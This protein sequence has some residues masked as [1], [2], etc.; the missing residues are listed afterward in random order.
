MCDQKSG[1]L[2]Q[3]RTARSTHL[4][5]PHLYFEETDLCRRARRAGWPTHYVPES[6]VTHIGSASTGIKTMSRPPNYWFDSR[7]HYFRKNL[8]AVGA[9]VANLAYIAGSLL[10]HLRC[11]IEHYNGGPVGVE[12]LAYAI[13]EARDAVEDVIEPFLMQQGFIQRTSRGRMAAGRAYLHLGLTPPK[14]TGQ[15][16]MFGE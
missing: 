10:F 16:D 6:V 14:K 9:L 8:G 13:A 3:E 15:G 4:S 1:S 2:W 5:I 12:T 11:M 7:Q